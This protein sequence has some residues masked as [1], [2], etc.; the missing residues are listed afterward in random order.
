MKKVTITTV[1][2]KRFKNFDQILKAWL[3]EEEVDQIIIWDNSGNFKTNLPGVLVISLSENVNSKWRLMCS[4]LCKNDL[5]II[6][7]DDFLPQ[8]GIIKDLLM[9]YQE[10]KLVGIMGRIFTGDT[11]YASK[12]VHSTGIKEPVKVDYLCTNLLLTHR[13]HC[14]GVDIRKIPSSLMVDWWWEHELEKEGVSFW[15][16]PSK[17]WKMLPEGDYKLSQHLDPRMKKIREYYFRKWIR[18]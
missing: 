3:D 9:Y 2:W 15:V 5:M 10:D 1:A 11:Y 17:K 18:K 14:L 4:Q 7:D 12:S 6:T 13:K 8:K 16:V